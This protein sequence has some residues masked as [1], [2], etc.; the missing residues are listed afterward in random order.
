MQLA[1][2]AEVVGQVLAVRGHRFELAASQQGSAGEA[3]VG[4]FHADGL[5]GKGRGVQFGVA[6]YLI[7]LGHVCPFPFFNP[8]KNAQ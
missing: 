1:I 5:A 6:V 7:P 3:A 2:A 8:L 4:R